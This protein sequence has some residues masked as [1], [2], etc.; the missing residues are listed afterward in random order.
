MVASASEKFWFCLIARRRVTGSMY[1]LVRGMGRT[2]I[3]LRITVGGIYLCTGT[4]IMNTV[5]KAFQI[6]FTVPYK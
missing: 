2:R 3:S 4:Q 1:I 6:R 5:I